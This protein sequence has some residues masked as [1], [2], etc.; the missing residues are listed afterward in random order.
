MQV[1]KPLPISH[2]VAR[3]LAQVQAEAQAATLEALS[4]KDRIVVLHPI[5]AAQV[6]FWAEDYVEVFDRVRSGTKATYVRRRQLPES[7][8]GCS[9]EADWHPSYWEVNLELSDCAGRLWK[10]V[11]GF[12]VTDDLGNLVQ[13]QRGEA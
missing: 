13:V 11:A 5:E 6:D 10:H 8:V 4:A 1:A 12:H 7:W 3:L 2:T 9:L